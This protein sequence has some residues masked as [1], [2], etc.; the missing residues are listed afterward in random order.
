M[1]RTK[2]MD[3][4]SL[5]NNNNNGWEKSSQTVNAAA[6]WRKHKDREMVADT[7]LRSI[8]PHI[9]RSRLTLFGN[10]LVDQKHALAIHNVHKKCTIHQSGGLS[11]STG[12]CGAVHFGFCRAI[13]EQRQKDLDV[14]SHIE[15]F[16]SVTRAVRAENTKHNHHHHKHS[17]SPTGNNTN[18]NNVAKL[19][20][21]LVK[22][23]THSSTK[24][25]KSPT[26][27]TSPGFSLRDEVAFTI[28]RMPIYHSVNI[29]TVY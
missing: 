24:E 29:I 15:R 19:F 7:S 17:S 27:P 14:K 20:I 26:T 5:S 18:S 4:M 10:V 23:S 2:N 28:H 12:D 6:F 1:I 11:G 8:T 16:E 3:I 22:K 13:E 21:P 25:K 9:V